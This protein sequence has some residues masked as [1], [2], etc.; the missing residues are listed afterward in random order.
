M[1][2]VATAALRVGVRY[3]PAFSVP[4]GLSLAE[5]ARRVCIR[6]AQPYVLVRDSATRVVIV[7]KPTWP[8]RT[9]LK[10]MLPG[11]SPSILHLS[12]DDA[13]WVKVSLSRQTVSAYEGDRLVRTMSASTGVS[14]GWATPRGTFWIYRKVAEDHMRG[15]GGGERWDVPHVPWAQY[16]YGGVAI[17][18]AWWTRRFGT[19]KSHGCIQLATRTFNPDPSGLPEDA[20]WLYRFTDLGTPVVVTGVTPPMTR[21]QSPSSPMP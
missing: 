14:P 16:I 1:Y 19:P 21:P 15:A 8:A 18:G 9:R 11:A 12:V 5:L 13:K 10:M 4:A 2:A 7:P 17:H 3:A 6:P 20:G